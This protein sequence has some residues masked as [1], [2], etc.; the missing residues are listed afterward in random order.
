MKEIFLALSI[1]LVLTELMVFNVGT[2]AQLLDWG[3]SI[4]LIYFVI[5]IYE[6]LKKTKV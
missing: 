5:G 1:V 3:F 4:T 2:E 6:R